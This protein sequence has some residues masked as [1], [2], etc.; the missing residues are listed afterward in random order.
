MKRKKEREIRWMNHHYCVGVLA[1]V[2]A[3]LTFCGVAKAA[4]VATANLT[5]SPSPTA[6]PGAIVKFQADIYYNSA[7]GEAPGTMM[8]IFVTRSDYSW[9]SDKIDIQYPGFG[10]VHVNFVNGFTIPAN[11]QS[12]Q[13]FDFYIVYGPWWVISN[14]ASVKVS[15]PMTIKNMKQKEYIKTSPAK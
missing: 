1:G 12:G 10:S 9:V 14:K 4:Q 3:L 6:K 8:R 5:A 2:L 7:F 13:V 15:F 11:A